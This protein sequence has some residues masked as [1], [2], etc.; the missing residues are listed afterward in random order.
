MCLSAPPRIK[1]A[2]SH[3]R[4]YGKTPLYRVPRGW[5]LNLYDCPGRVDF[6]ELGRKFDINRRDVGLLPS[7]LSRQFDF[8]LPGR[9][10]VVIFEFAGRVGE[11]LLQDVGPFI[12]AGADYYKRLEYIFDEMLFYY[13]SGNVPRA[14]SLLW[15]LL[16]E[17]SDLLDSTVSSNQIHPALRLAVDYISASLRSDLSAAEVAKVSGISH[18]HLN[19]LFTESFGLSINPYIRDRRMKEAAGLLVATDIP[20]KEIAAECGIADLQK[21]N[22][23]FRLQFG[24]SPR[25]YRRQTVVEL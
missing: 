8:D 21:F 15:N 6:P 25:K 1:L 24:L 9:Q 5:G 4:Q 12:M 2:H 13:N 18:N 17:L 22:K 19:R 20:I 16:W 7:G 23:S 11:N 3:H 10:R 14:E